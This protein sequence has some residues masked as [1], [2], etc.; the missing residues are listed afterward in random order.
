MKRYDEYSRE[1][2]SALRDEL[3]QKYNDYK[4]RGLSLDL[5]RG[6]PNS[7]QLDI[8]LPLL[9]ESRPREKI[10]RAHV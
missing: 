7:D 2:L 3:L 10:G 4:S 6:K 5:S 1:E 9:S 8:S